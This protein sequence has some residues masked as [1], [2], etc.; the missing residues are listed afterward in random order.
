[1]CTVSRSSFNTCNKVVCADG[2]SVNL[3]Y[4]CYLLCVCMCMLGCF[5]FD[6]RQTASPCR[7][8]R[9]RERGFWRSCCRALCAAD[10]S[11]E[12]WKG[13]RA[14]HAPRL[15]S[16]PQNLCRQRGER[17]ARTAKVRLG[18]RGQRHLA[19]RNRKKSLGSDARHAAKWPPPSRGRGAAR[20]P[21][22]QTLRTNQTSTWRRVAAQV[23]SGG[24]G[25][26]Y[27][28]ARPFGLGLFFFFFFRLWL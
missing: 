13:G 27:A 26:V 3:R 6:A 1:M 21:V 18:A 11:A 8:Y 5:A 12:R 23:N 7:R 20:V 17:T 10:V 4:A 16:M 14:P 25:W 15:D 19:Q 9:G 22:R 28:S 2:A 24:G